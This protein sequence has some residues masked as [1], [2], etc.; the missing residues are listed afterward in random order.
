MKKSHKKVYRTINFKIFIPTVAILLIESI[1]ILMILIFEVGSNTLNSALIDA[2]ES[3]INIRKNYME[4]SMSNKWAN[5]SNFYDRFQTNAETFL[6]SSEKT[7]DE[8]LA[9]KSLTSDFILKQMDIFPDMIEKNHVTDTFLVLNTSYSDNKDMLYLRNKN[10]LKTENSEIEVIYSPYAVFDAYYKQGFGL[11]VNVDTNKYADIENKDFYEETFNY[12][13]SHINSSSIGYWTSTLNISSNQV[14]TYSYPIKISG[15]TVGVFGV[16]LTQ[17]YLRNYISSISKGDNLN[18]ALLRKQSNKSSSAFQAYVDYH[19]PNLE[20]VTLSNTSFENVYT[21]TNENVEILY[22]EDEI[23]VYNG[24]SPFSDEWFIVGASPKNVVLETTN[25]FVT[26]VSIVVG[27]SFFAASFALALASEM[28][29]KPIKKVSKAISSDN[30]NAIPETK[31]H[32]V[33][34]LVNKIQTSMRNN[35]ELNNKVTKI[36]ED[37]SSRIA[38]FEYSSEKDEIATTSVFYKM[39]NLPYSNGKVSANTFISRLKERKSA[40]QSMT[41]PFI[42]KG[43]LKEAGNITFVI[44]TR[45]NKLN[46]TTNS[47]GAFATL[48]DSTDEYLAKKEIEK[49]RDSDVLTGLLNRRGFLNSIDKVYDSCKNGSLFMIDVDNLKLIN[50]LYGHEFGDLY[51]KSIGSFILG[52]A[53]KHKNLL[54]SHISGDEFV[55]FLYDYQ[56]NDEVR[57]LADELKEAEKVYVNFKGKEIYISFSCGVY[58]IEK[59]VDFEES[60][61]RADFAMYEAKRLGKNKI[62]FFDQNESEK[63]H[64]ENILGDELNEIITNKL[65]DYAYQPIVS[66]KTGEVLGYEALM[67][68]KIEGMSPLKVV[69]AAKKYNRLYDIE[70][71]TLFN[72]AKKYKESKTDKKIFINSISSQI[73]SDIAWDDFIKDN[74]SILDKLVIEI[75]EEDFS[76]NAILKKKTGILEKNHISYAIDDYGTGFNSISMI[77]DF[78]PKYIKIEGS[79]I[80][81]IDKDEKK[82]QLTRTIVSYCKVN[83]IQ[84]V[85]EAVET[86]EELKYVKSIGCDFVQG[87]LVSKPKFT[88]E[89]VPSEIKNLI[90][91]A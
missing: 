68:P 48:V 50:D 51:L 17:Q 10:P 70:Y 22:Y 82:K 90:K 44:G 28:V 64:K 20:D 77:L 47:Y 73:L 65:L 3:S 58:L 16:G 52:I 84:V 91:E 31:I 8:V 49:E 88:I 4:S 69:E 19:L 33:D 62:V 38:F 41:Y 86:I 18:V 46:I 80:R 29:S 78:S 79:L 23:N 37:V 26:Q 81:G 66:I 5:I 72:A 56:S 15:K 76:E 14:L 36:M 1:A 12:S 25:K 53:E 43:I 11:S 85:A 54:V 32:E 27:I 59:G 6:N 35:N 9:S 55:L 71:L 83:G 67:R 39:L 87:Y 60:R 30:L 61:N 21:F 42:N 45:C 74:E 89:E 57:K 40:I 2:F 34:M 24:E 13:A 7:M 75:I 63:Y